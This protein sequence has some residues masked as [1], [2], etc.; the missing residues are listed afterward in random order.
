M[1]DILANVRIPAVV[2]VLA[3]TGCGQLDRCL[4]QRA[5]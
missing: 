2:V 1:S 4:I 3:L 5:A